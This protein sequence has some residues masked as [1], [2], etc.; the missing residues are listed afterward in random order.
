MASGLT[1]QAPG[2]N[3]ITDE[4]ARALAARFENPLISCS[5]I[6]QQAKLEGLPNRQ[7]NLFAVRTLVNLN[8]VQYLFV[9]F[10]DLHT[11]EQVSESRI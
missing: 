6:L 3:F 8:H 11:P 4:Q 7:I 9:L 5:P 10:V 1:Y 2:F